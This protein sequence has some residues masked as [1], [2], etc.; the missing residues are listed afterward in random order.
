MVWR[1]RYKTP[2]SGSGC[3]IHRKLITE[4]EVEERCLLKNVEKGARKLLLNSQIPEGL[5]LS[6][7]TDWSWG[8][9][10]LVHLGPKLLIVLWYSWPS[11][12]W[13]PVLCSLGNFN[14]DGVD[15]SQSEGLGILEKK[16]LGTRQHQDALYRWNDLLNLVIRALQGKR[17]GPCR[18]S[19]TTSSISKLMSAWNLM[20]S[21]ICIQGTV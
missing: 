12:D 18:A 6:I 9:E 19:C 15:S 11:F 14:D 13:W 7:L 2:K 21:S 8:F 5:G 20:V 10:V 1:S 3:L 17:W 4:A 16:V